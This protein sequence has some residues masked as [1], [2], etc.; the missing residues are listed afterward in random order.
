MDVGLLENVIHEVKIQLSI[1]KRRILAERSVDITSA[2]RA[3]LC[4]CW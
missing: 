2:S 1:I 4:F 3:L